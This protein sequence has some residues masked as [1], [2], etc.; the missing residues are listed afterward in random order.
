MT[1]LEAVLIM[2][3]VIGAF[4]AG[5]RL[6][7]YYQNKAANET[8]TALEKQFLRLKSGSDADDPCRPYGTPVFQHP[9]P[10]NYPDDYRKPVVDQAFMDE[11][12]STGKAKTVFRKSDL[13]K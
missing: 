8:K 1:V 11:L 6:D 7:A 3:M 10:T 13:S 9:I 2:L 5:L 12:K 4:V